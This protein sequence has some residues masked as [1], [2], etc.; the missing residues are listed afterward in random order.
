MTC[1][2]LA[3]FRWSGFVAMKLA[4]RTSFDQSV[5]TESVARTIGMYCRKAARCLAWRRVDDLLL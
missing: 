1:C 3:V 5:P 2:A 4:W